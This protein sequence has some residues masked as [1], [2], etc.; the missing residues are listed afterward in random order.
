MPNSAPSSPSWTTPTRPNGGATVE[1]LGVYLSE[2]H[3]G[4]VAHGCVMPSLSA[5]VSRASDSVR[6]VYQ[7]RML[8]LVALLA[9]AMPGPPDEQERR[10]WAAVASMVGAVTI[11]RA[12]PDGDHA[13][14]VLDAALQATTNTAT[15]NPA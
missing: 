1:F 5:D 2:D 12:L 9:P 15:G 7:R 14:S 11:A 3:R 4:D 13:K 10:A 8:D 6:E